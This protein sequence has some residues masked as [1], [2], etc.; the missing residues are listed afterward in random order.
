MIEFDELFELLKEIEISCDNFNEENKEKEKIIL[1]L[2][3]LNSYINDI[4]HSLKVKTNKTYKISEIDILKKIISKK[5][6]LENVLKNCNTEKKHILFKKINNIGW[7]VKHDGASLSN[8]SLINQNAILE[9]N[10]NINEKDM[11]INH[12]KENKQSESILFSEKRGIQKKEISN[13]KQNNILSH[14]DKVNN[15]NSNLKKFDD[16]ELIKDNLIKEWGNQIDEYDNLKYEFTY[17]YKKI[18]FQKKLD[19][20]KNV[21]AFKDDNIDDELCLLAQEMKEN[22]LAYRQILVDDNKTLEVSAT[23][24]ANNIDSILNVNKK[25]KKMGSNH[26]ISFFLSLIIIGVSILLFIF[27]FFVIILL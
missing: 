13:D 11:N 15:N 2:N 19:K 25:T 27:T 10:L 5:E 26:S 20:R 17:E 14:N 7:E 3:D 18:E 4:S 21:N 23:K 6:R 24:Q 9:R 1:F 8:Q 12:D 22:V 16:C